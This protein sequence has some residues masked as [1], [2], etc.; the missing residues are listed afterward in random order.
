MLNETTMLTK[1]AGINEYL[2]VRL[3]LER[4]LHRV[5]RQCDAFIRAVED[6]VGTNNI[7]YCAT[8]AISVQRRESNSLVRKLRNNS[9]KMW[10]TIDN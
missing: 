8:R 5:N 9:V 6:G 3:W 7:S 4:R 10:T 1:S 2:H